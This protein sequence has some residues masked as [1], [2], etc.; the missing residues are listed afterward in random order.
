M[1]LYEI[2]AIIYFEGMRI[3]KRQ[4]AQATAAHSRIGELFV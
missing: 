3:R 2:I 4:F 1:Y